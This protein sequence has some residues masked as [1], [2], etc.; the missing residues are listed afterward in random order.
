M[1]QVKYNFETRKAFIHHVITQQGEGHIVAN[2]AKM[3]ADNSFTC[4]MRSIPPVTGT[5]IL[6]FI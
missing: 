3:N 2:E 5:T 6:T 1:K 4:V